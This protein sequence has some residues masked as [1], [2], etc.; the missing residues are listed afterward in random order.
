MIASNRLRL[1][2][3]R[4]CLCAFAFCAIDS[5]AAAS[6]TVEVAG[7]GEAV[8]GAVVSLHSASA[9]AAARPMSA[10]LDQRHAEFAPRVLP[11]TTG[12]R[13]AFTNSDDRRHHIY[14]F[15]S[16]H[17][18]EL[19]LD[20]DR[21][22]QSIVFDTPGVV[23]LGCSIHDWML[24]YVVVLDTP[25]FA[26]TDVDG[27]AR[28]KAPPGVYTLQVWHERL[29]DAADVRTTHQVRVGAGRVE[30][31][32]LDLEAPRKALPPAD[33]RLQQLRQRFKGVERGG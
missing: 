15:S 4:W 20:A 28:L 19:P 12:S 14:S 18:F 5:A 33:A 2:L 31:V 32:T 7:N 6:L 29:D 10:A 16:A 30:R 22:A 13:V 17:R 3:R 9:R 27:D 24:G 21:Q 1:W 26:M 25:Y 11:V 23:E 8:E